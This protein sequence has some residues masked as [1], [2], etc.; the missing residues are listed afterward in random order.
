MSASLPS[1]PPTEPHSPDQR[2][3]T[4]DTVLQPLVADSFLT[5]ADL[6]SAFSE[7]VGNA[8]TL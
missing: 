3:E 8:I 7:A 2:T 4:G 1:P 5:L 6:F